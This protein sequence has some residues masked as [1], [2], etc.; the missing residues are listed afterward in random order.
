MKKI[1]AFVKKHD[2]ILLFTADVLVI[3]ALLLCKKM[4]EVMFAT[5]APCRW[6][7][8]GLECATCGGT[9]C[10]S[11]LLDGRILASYAY[12][13]MIFSAIAALALFFV[14]LNLSVFFKV[15]AAKKI[16]AYVLHYRT[17]IFCMT[18]F[19]TFFVARNFVP[20][21]EMLI[22]I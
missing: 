13:P 9:R 12:N 1:S 18:V 21:I 7:L 14:L 10:V 2:K 4:T 17:V 8:F 19:L 11:A 15:K 16:I 20:L 6:T 3:P 5:G 22:G